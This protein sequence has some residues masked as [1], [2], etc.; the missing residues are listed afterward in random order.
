MSCPVTSCLVPSGVVQ[1]SPVPFVLSHSYIKELV[2]SCL[3]RSRLVTSSRV[4]Y[5]RVAF[6]SYHLIYKR[7][8][9]VSSSLV[10]SSLVSSSL[11][12]SG[13]VL[14]RRVG[15]R[16]VSSDLVPLV[17]YIP[18]YRFD[19]EAAPEALPGGPE[20]AHADKLARLC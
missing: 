5:S 18:F 15:S 13:Q 17:S 3:V 20:K 10:L 4:R 2:L 7:A 19:R 16:H 6:G 14:S 8:C 9:L 1:S 12:L 11:V